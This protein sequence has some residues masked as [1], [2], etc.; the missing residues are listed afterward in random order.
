MDSPEQRERKMNFVRKHVLK[1]DELVDPEPRPGED[2]HLLSFLDSPEQRA[3]KQRYVDHIQE[4]IKQYY[5][6]RKIDPSQK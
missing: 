6:R 5:L 1:H 4:D 2:P 3:A